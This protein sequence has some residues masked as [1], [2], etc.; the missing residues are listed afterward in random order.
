MK[1]FK[2]ILTDSLFNSFKVNL[3]DTVLTKY[4]YDSATKN[5]VASTF[6][7]LILIATLFTIAQLYYLLSDIISGNFYTIES[8]IYKDFGIRLE[9]D[10]LIT[11][12]GCENLFDYPLDIENFIIGESEK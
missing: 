11:E 3:P 5:L 2:E 10:Y 8:G 1:K 7:T 12:S 4:Q 6:K 9:N